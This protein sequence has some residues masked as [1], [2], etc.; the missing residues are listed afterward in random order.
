MNKPLAWTIADL[1]KHREQFTVTA[2]AVVNSAKGAQASVENGVATKRNGNG[3]HRTEADK[4]VSFYAAHMHQDP[5]GQEDYWTVYETEPDNRAFASYHFMLLGAKSEQQFHYHPPAK[6]NDGRPV[7]ESS[8]RHVILFPLW[9]QSKDEGGV[10]LE[11]FET[12]DTNV[13]NSVDTADYPYVNAN[14]VAPKYTLHMPAGHIAMVSFGA[15]AHRFKGHALAISGHFLDIDTGSKF[16][17]FMANTAGYKGSFPNVSETLSVD[18]PEHVEDKPF[19]NS[20]LHDAFS[21]HAQI[22]RNY[23]DGYGG[24]KLAP[25]LQK[26]LVHDLRKSLAADLSPA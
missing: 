21:I 22:M 4:A 25:E 3:R 24:K 9:N 13:V 6:G 8:I 2:S 26:Q 12:R 18:V 15:G 20:F 19:S 17:P 16:D 10:T 23:I 5:I 11:W 7:K 14:A 1:S